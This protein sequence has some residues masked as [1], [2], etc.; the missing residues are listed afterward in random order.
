MVRPDAGIYD[1][2]WTTSA[3]AAP[4]DIFV[5]SDP[6]GDVGEARQIADDD[7]DGKFELSA[8]ESEERLYFL[9]VPEN[10]EAVRIAS[11]LLPLEGGRN[12]RDLGG[13]ETTNGQHVK[14]GRL[15]RSGTMTGLTD[16]DYEYLSSLGI[17]TIVDFRTSEERAAEPTK[18]RAGD[19][20]YETFP[21]PA[22]D[23][24][25]PLAAV[26][27]SP[28]VKPE[29]VR[30]MMTHL[31]SE[32]LEQQT[33]AYRVLFHDLTDD[34]AP[35]V[36]NCSAG[37]DRTGVG[38]ALIL[39]VLGVPRDAVVADYALSEKLV[40]YSA[41]FQL[42]ADGEASQDDNSPYAYLRRL[43][44]ELVAPLMRSDPAYIEAVLDRIDQDYGSVEAFVREE[45][46]VSVEDLAHIRRNLLED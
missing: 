42:G 9:L 13:Y 20:S 22:E 31:Y 16:K 34:N 27:A 37:K 15:F 6:S 43:P 35:L 11:R 38:A 41:E 30:A 29:D 45:L 26:F 28:D 17:A 18:W 1:I 5:T 25:N 19:I 46:D 24:A 44:P 23:D 3:A 4:V 12:F 8:P 36:F 14:W 10:G 7:T 32:I 2:T 40:D 33:P 39:S 21:D